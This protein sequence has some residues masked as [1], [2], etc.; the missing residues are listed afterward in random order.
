[1]RSFYVGHCK[2]LGKAHLGKLATGKCARGRNNHSAKVWRL[3]SPKGEVFV[4]KN[5]RQF[6]RENP[7]MFDPI[8]TEWRTV[9]G[10]PLGSIERICNAITALSRLNPNRKEVRGVWKGWTWVSI[11]ERRENDGDTL[12]NFKP[13]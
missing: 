10:L 2:K 4:F 5:L 7:H 6:V 9:P 13:L 12:L 8:D 11:I 1:M 3:R